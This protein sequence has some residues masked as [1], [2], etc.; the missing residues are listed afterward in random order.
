MI[1]NI[2]FYQ[3]LHKHS[4]QK[5]SESLNNISEEELR[6]QAYPDSKSIAWTVSNLIIS[7]TRFLESLKRTGPYLPEKSL[8]HYSLGYVTKFQE[9]FSELQERYA[10]LLGPL[11]K[12]DL[13]R[14]LMTADSDLLSLEIALEMQLIQVAGYAQHIPFLRTLYASAQ[15]KTKS[16]L[17]RW[18]L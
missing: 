10:R 15:S 14:T 7:E 11:C 17:A 2:R 6:W 3:H 13:K 9:H 12:E 16:E 1:D 4:Y 5:L 18:C 8:K